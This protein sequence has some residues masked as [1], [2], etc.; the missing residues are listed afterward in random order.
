MAEFGQREDLYNV[1]VIVTGTDGN[2][3]K[4]VFDKMSGGNVTAKV[5]KYR[6]ANGTQ[7]EKILGGGKSVADITIVGLMTFDMYQ[8]VP[9]M[10]DQTGKAHVNINKQ[11]LDLDGNPYGKALTYYGRLTDTKP[12]DTD[13][14]SENAGTLTLTATVSTPVTTG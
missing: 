8:W 2:K 1:T 14:S 6:A 13:A 10:M 3:A 7:D 12:P 9:W 4:F 11:P 5:T